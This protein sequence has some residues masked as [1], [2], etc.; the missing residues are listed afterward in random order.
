MR[1]R[2]DVDPEMKRNFLILIAVSYLVV[3]PLMAAQFY[4]SYTSR[5]AASLVTGV[6]LATCY[7][8]LFF[9]GRRNGLW[10]R[11][12]HGFRRRRQERRGGSLH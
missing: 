6:V 3:L 4:F 7:I 2:R 5:T 10:T 11:S 9:W 12:L 1:Q 8:L